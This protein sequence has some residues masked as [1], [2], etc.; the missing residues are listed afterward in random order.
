[1]HR[2]KISF[3]HSRSSI[4]AVLAV[5]FFMIGAAIQAED[6]N[7]LTNISNFGQINENYYRGG[8]PKGQDYADLA[9]LGVRTVVNLTSHDAEKNEKGMVENAGMKYVQIPMT[10]HESPSG[11]KLKRFLEVVNDPGN[12]PV[13]V[14][15]VGG[16][17]RTGVMTAVYR[18]TQE[19]WSADQAYKEM[20][21]YN[22]GPSFFHPEFKSF[23]FDYHEELAR[24]RSTAAPAAAVSGQ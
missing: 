9:R 11:S 22:F 2:F 19:G 7:S 23:V 4:T 24:Q 18:M 17:H 16:K 15:C 20:K 13:F 1:V 6:R 14:H 21:D 12:Q 8:Q 10:T 5:F 3:D